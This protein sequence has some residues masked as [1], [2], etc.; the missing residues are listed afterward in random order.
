MSSNLNENLKRLASELEESN[1]VKTADDASVVVTLED[2]SPIK[3][4]PKECRKFF[5]SVTSVQAFCKQITS[6]ESAS[7][8]LYSITLPDDVLLE[9][10]ERFALVEEV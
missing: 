1:E 7:V 4:E 6:P 10:E 5:A 3:L 8:E 9:L 2:G